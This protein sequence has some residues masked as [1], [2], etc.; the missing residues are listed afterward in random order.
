M[1]E[2]LQNLYLKIDIIIINGLKENKIFKLK[3]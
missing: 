2:T 3:S 1:Q